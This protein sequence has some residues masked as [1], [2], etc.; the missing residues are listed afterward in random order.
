MCLEDDVSKGGVPARDVPASAQRERQ[1]H[2]N[3]NGCRLPPERARL[4]APLTHGEN[5]LPVEAERRIERSSDADSVGIDG[6]VRTNHDLQF[7]LPLHFG[8]H[9]VA[10][11]VRPDLAYELR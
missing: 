1:F 11:V 9:G 6:T 3:T 8:A 4:E 2:E 10:G 7:D 5:R